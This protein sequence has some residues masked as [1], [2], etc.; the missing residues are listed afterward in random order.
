MKEEE[1]TYMGKLLSTH[2]F[3]L[4]LLLL[5]LCCL[6]FSHVIDLH[7]LS[8]N[9]RK[10]RERGGGNADPAGNSDRCAVRKNFNLI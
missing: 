6:S 8:D 3:F 9:R 7:T 10:R 4:L 2:S 5:L 1:K